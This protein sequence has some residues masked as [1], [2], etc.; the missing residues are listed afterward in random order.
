MPRSRAR[1]FC[2]GAG[3][4]QFWKEEEAGEA[5]VADVRVREAGETGASVVAAGCPFCKVMLASAEGAPAVKDVAQLLDE[6]YGGAPGPT[7]PDDAPA[8]K[9]RPPTAGA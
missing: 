9:P 8:A 1:S 2:C 4:A 7:S 5:K 6:A 3:G